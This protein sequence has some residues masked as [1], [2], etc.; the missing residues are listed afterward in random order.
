MSSGPAKRGLCRLRQSHCKWCWF[1]LIISVRLSRLLSVS[2]IFR[3]IFNFCIDFL[4]S[5]FFII[6]SRCVIVWKHPQQRSNRRNRGRRSS[7]PWSRS[8]RALFLPQTSTKTSTKPTSS[9]TISS[10]STSTTRFNNLQR[11]P[12]TVNLRFSTDDTVEHALFIHVQRTIHVHGT[13]DSRD[14]E[15]ETDKKTAAE[16]SRPDI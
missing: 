11:L 10:A 6:S 15:P 9:P 8:R 14:G 12:S 13:N 3:I 16:A 5:S 4:N 7:G 1:W 2:L